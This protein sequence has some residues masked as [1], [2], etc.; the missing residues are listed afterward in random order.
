L[1]SYLEEPEPVDTDA[2]F[3]VLGLIPMR[4]CYFREVATPFR[5][6]RHGMLYDL[7]TW[8]KW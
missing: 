1:R 7:R 3:V 4:S 2:A 6:M 5:E 8:F